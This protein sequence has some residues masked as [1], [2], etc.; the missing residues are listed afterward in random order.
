VTESVGH[1]T[2]DVVIT[3]ITRIEQ[4][5]GRFA[6]V[7]KAEDGEMLFRAQQRL[8]ESE[9]D[10]DRFT[11]LRIDAAAADE[12]DRLLQIK[13]LRRIGRGDRLIAAITLA[14]GAKLITRNLKHFQKVPGLP[15]ENWAD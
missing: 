15:I 5:Q 4:L 7:L 2:Q 13:G 12:F 1:A 8:Q 11:S 6:S 9:E 10:L 3:A 14:N